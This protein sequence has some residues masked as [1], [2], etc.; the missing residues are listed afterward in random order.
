MRQ[1]AAVR[2]RESDRTLGAASGSSSTTRAFPR[3]ARTPSA[4]RASIQARWVGITAKSPRAASGRGPRE[5]LHWHAP[6]CRGVDHG[7]RALSG[8][9]RTPRSPLRKWQHALEDHALAAGVRRHVVLGD[10]AG[11]VTA[12]RAALTARGLPYHL[13]ARRLGRVMPARRGVSGR[14]R[15][16]PRPAPRTSPV[17]E[18]AATLPHR[19]R[20]GRDRAARKPPTS[21]PC[22]YASPTAA[23]APARIRE[24]PPSLSLLVAAEDA[25]PHLG[26][27]GETALA[28]RAQEMKGELGLDH[29][30]GRPARRAVCRRPCLPRPP[31]GAFPPDNACCGRSPPC[32]GSSRSCGAAQLSVMRPPH[33]R[34]INRAGRRECDQVVRRNP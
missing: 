23:Q 17:I 28:Y 10:A 3:K 20:G 12:F 26:A 30:E 34:R 33:K 1:R 21:P 13:R 16:I 24:C 14:P 19:R 4:S 32:V 5:R 31:P 25:P 6:V 29:F 7:P 22:G 18:L 15:S 27:P 2:R 8:G 9:G 11:D